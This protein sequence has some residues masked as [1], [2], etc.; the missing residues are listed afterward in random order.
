QRLPAKVDFNLHGCNHSSCPQWPRC[1]PA[2]SLPQR[3]EPWY[4]FVEINRLC[5][6]AGQGNVLGCPMSKVEHI[7]AQIARL[8]EQELADFRAWYREFD[9]S[10]WDEQ[11]KRDT[12]SGKLDALADA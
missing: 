6:A 11:I 9:A 12:T 1:R 3:V 10:A 5:H 7:E 4:C 2:T 8:S